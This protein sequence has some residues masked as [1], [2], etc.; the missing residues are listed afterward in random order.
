VVGWPIP[1]SSKG[2]PCSDSDEFALVIHQLTIDDDIVDPGRNL[3]GPD[4]GS[5]VKN[6]GGVEDGDVREESS[7]LPGRRS[8]AGGVY[9]LQQQPLLRLLVGRTP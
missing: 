4:V 8:A 7:K 3:I 2:A 5:V 6:G 9:A 1:A